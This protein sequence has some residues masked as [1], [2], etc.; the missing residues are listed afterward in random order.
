MVG[1]EEPRLGEL[2]VTDTVVAATAAAAAALLV[3]TEAVTVAR[4]LPLVE[5]FSV[6][7]L[8]R[9]SDDIRHVVSSDSR[10]SAGAKKF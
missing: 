6:E 1:E 9:F 2:P 5:R 7:L 8:Y 3:A 10:I 4:A